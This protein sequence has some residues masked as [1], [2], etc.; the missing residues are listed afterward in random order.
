MP[1]VEHVQTTDEILVGKLRDNVN[2]LCKGNLE[3]RLQAID[4]LIDELKKST[5]SMASVPKPMKHLV[6]FLDDLINAYNTFSNDEFKR[7]LADLLSLLSIIKID[8]SYDMLV[9]RLASP[10]ENIGSWGHEYVRCLTLVLTRAFD[11]PEDVPAGVDLNPLIEQISKYYMDHNDEPDACDLLLN[12]EKLDDIIGLVDEE[13]HVRVCTYLLQCYNYLPD[14]V[15]I[16]VLH[17]VEKI[18]SNLHKTVQSMVI[19]LKLN[20][21]ELMH[22]IFTNCTDESEKKQLAFLLARQLIV[23]DD[24]DS[25]LVDIATNTELYRRFIEVSNCLGRSKPKTPDDVLQLQATIGNR[26]ARQDK[27]WTMLAKSF[28]AAFHNAGIKEDLY[29]TTV[30]GDES[31]MRNRGIYRSVPVA[32]IGMLNLWDIE[33]GLNVLDKYTRSDDLNMVMGALTGIGIISSAVRSEFDPAIALIGD[34]LK[35]NDENVLVGAIFGL[36]MAY[37][38]SVRQDIFQLLLPLLQSDNHRIYSYAALASGLIFVGSPE[39]EVLNTLLNIVTNIEDDS[40]PSKYIPLLSLG[41]GLMFMGKQSQCKSIIQCIQASTKDT[42]LSKFVQTTITACAYAGTG[43]VLII[44]ELLRICTGEDS[45]QHSAAVLGIAMIALGDSVSCQMAQRMFEHILQYGKPSARLMVPIAYA[46]TSI[47]NP[48]PELVDT[49][50]RIGHDTD[51]NICSNAAIAIGLLAAGTQNT[52]AINTLRALASFHKSNQQI[53]CLL[54][55]AEGLTQL[56]QGLM[57][58]APTYGDSTLLHPVA[59][60]SLLAVA[61]SCINTTEL[62]LNQ[63]PLL[64]FFV[65]PAIGQR[66][67]VTLDEDLNVLPLQV[68]VGTAI[69]VVGQAGRPRTITGFQTLDT[70]VILASGQRAEFVDSTYEPLSPILEGFVIVRKKAVTTKE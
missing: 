29:Y 4:F 42:I 11:H 33:E 9:Y 12:V 64:L 1:D 51:T 44:Q 28:V 2:I 18:Y 40:F 24:M 63:D 55:I 23:F 70:P 46:L 61:F 49:L 26:N 13:S 8:T 16:Q 22:E 17:T 69:D 58:L 31:I 41:L 39:D 53:V 57:T 59:L 5:S 68:R 65:A 50:H 54:Q 34:S 36:A 62:V 52:R 37:A 60:G 47:S 67:L 32:G 14:P 48:L 27:T 43:N 45:I 6:P 25:E 3:E 21:H 7:K 15:N 10:I 35:H 20:D 56:G 66:F 30:R 19:A 38:G